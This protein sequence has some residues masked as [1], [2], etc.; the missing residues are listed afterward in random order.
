MLYEAFRWWR[1][2]KKVN[3]RHK[4]SMEGE[5]AEGQSGIWTEVGHANG[6]DQRSSAAGVKK[7]Q[8]IQV[9]G[10][11]SGKNE[12]GQG[13]G[14]GKGVGGRKKGTKGKAIAP[15]VRTRNADQ[16]TGSGKQQNG[17]SEPSRRWTVT[18]REAFA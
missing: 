14:G 16:N 9:S 7:T 12:G 6:T 18:S 4:M 2:N 17:E 15:D 1:A 13:S 8:N 10:G 5:D 11:S 3:R